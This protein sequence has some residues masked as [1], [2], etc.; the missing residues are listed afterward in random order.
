MQ[1]PTTEGCG[2]HYLSPRNKMSSGIGKKQHRT[3]NIW[4]MN[5]FDNSLKGLDTTKEGAVIQTVARY[6]L[7]ILRLAGKICSRYYHAYQLVVHR[8]G[9]EL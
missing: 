3:S 6:G 5:T 8:D 7:E 2:A 4:W 9:S 1:L